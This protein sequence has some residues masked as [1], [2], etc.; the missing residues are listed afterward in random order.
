MVNFGNVEAIPRSGSVYTWSN[1]QDGDSRIYSKIDHVFANEE[2]FDM[3]PNSKVLFRWETISDHCSCTIATASSNKIGFKPFRYHN[4][5]VKHSEFKAAVMK[6][7]EK[8]IAVKGIL[9]L[10][11]KLMRLKHCLKNFSRDFIG[12]IGKTNHAAKNEFHESKLLAQSHLREP[13]FLEKEKLG[14]ENFLCKEKMYH[15][16]L[17]QHSKITWLHKGD[18][19]TSF[20]HA[21]LKKRKIENR[22]T[23]YITEQEIIVDNFPKVVDHF[24]SHFQ[25]YMGSPHLNLNQQLALLKPFTNKEIKQ[26]LFSIPDTKSPGADGYG[27]RFFNQLQPDLGAEFCSAMN[28]IG[29]MPLELHSTL[30]SLIPKHENPTSSVDYRPIAYCTI[31]YKCISKLLCTRLAMVLPNLINQNQGVFIQERFIAH[32]VM[33]LQDLLKNYKRKMS[34]YDALSKLTLAR[35]MILSTSYSIVMNGRVEGG[36]KGEKGGN[37]PALFSHLQGGSIMLEP[38]RNWHSSNTWCIISRP[39]HHYFQAVSSEQKG[40][41]A[42]VCWAIWGARNNLVWQNKEFNP[43]N[44]V[45]FA[46]SYLDQW[47]N[48]RKSNMDASWSEYQIGN[49][50]EHWTPPN[51]NSIK[52]NMDATLFEGGH[53]FGMALWPEILIGC[54][55]KV[56]LPFP[57]VW[58]NHLLLKI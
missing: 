52:I 54:L 14:A 30:I 38:C 15:S 26:V 47:K 23:S 3:F 12:D 9:A 16:F 4:F 6:N 33:I 10:Y 19:N 17:R 32:N 8:P 25:G 13:L 29:F 27:S 53:S 46:K 43:G 39:V 58:L 1:N 45:V 20:F 24:V 51:V 55:L 41:M 21:C 11:L 2:W 35:L 28:S 57:L 7:W 48:A 18:E 42:A 37:N 34:P 40:L 36:L 49:G 50:R 22:I 5:W 44:V 31:V 56:E